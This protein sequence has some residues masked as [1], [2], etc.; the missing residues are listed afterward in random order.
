MI[1]FLKGQ[2]LTHN[3]Q[4]SYSRFFSLILQILILVLVFLIHYYKSVAS[5]NF[6]ITL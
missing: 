6:N 3:L 5:R 4:K 1:L 2:L